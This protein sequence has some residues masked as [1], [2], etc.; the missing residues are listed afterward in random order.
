MTYLT[1]VIVLL[2][3]YHNQEPTAVVVDPD[4]STYV[5]VN[6]VGFTASAMVTEVSA[7]IDGAAIPPENILFYGYTKHPV[8]STNKYARSINVDTML[9]S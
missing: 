6:Y 3:V 5:G 7:T 8:N 1:Q 4:A 9:L 2:I